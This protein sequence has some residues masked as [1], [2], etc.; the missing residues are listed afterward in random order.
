MLTFPPSKLSELQKC[1]GFAN[2]APFAFC[3]IPIPHPHATFG[4]QMSR[5]LLSE[6]VPVQPSSLVGCPPSVISVT[7]HPSAHVPVFPTG[8]D[9]C[10]GRRCA[11]QI[12]HRACTQQVLNYL[13][14][15]LPLQPQLSHIPRSS[16]L[17]SF[18]PCTMTPHL[19][20]TDSPS[21]AFYPQHSRPLL[22]TQSA[23]CRQTLM[24]KTHSHARA[25]HCCPPLT[26]F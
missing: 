11:P 24:S 18:V 23:H 7:L 15:Q 8:W 6:F 10:E 21:K 12:L 4:I 14:P 25:G 17:A 1:T 22:P 2:A 19:M 3:V 13:G 9:T 5:P 26:H 16:P 20:Q